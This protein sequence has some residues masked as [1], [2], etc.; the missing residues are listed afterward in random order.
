ML[1]ATI[2]SFIDTNHESVKS[3]YC[4]FQSVKSSGEQRF[5]ECV[6]PHSIV[7]SVYKERQTGQ[8]MTLRQSHYYW[9][10]Q[11]A[12]HPVMHPSMF[13]ISHKKRCKYACHS[14]LLLDAVLSFILGNSF[15]RLFHFQVSIC[16]FGQNFYLMQPWTEV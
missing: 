2:H 7:L 10:I 5:A 9:S 15:S 13:Q 16:D 4:S 8:S 1:R 3:F 6:V 11:I 12:V 14:F